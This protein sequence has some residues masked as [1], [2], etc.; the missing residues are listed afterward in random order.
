[1]PAIRYCLRA[2]AVIP[3]LLDRA[4]AG[5][6]FDGGRMPEDGAESFEMGLIYP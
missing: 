3:S 5:G 6:V 1:M 2:V 4:A